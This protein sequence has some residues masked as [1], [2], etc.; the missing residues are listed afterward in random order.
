MADTRFS[1]FVLI[2][3]SAVPLALL[4]WD[5][6]HHQLGAD[7]VNYAIHTTGWLA[8]MYLMVSLCVTPLRKITRL[9]WLVAFRR[10]LG[11]YGFIYAACHLAIYFWWDRAHSFTSTW[12]EI[13]GKPFIT[14]GF[15][16]LVLLTPLALTST[17]AMI[18][19]LGP[20]RWGWLHTLAYPA[21]ALAALHY[22]LEGK[23]VTFDKKVFAAGIASLLAIRWI[24]R[25]VI[26]PKQPTGKPAVAT[27]AG[28]AKPK[29]W[30]GQL[31]IARIFRET[32]TVQTF[33][34]AATDGGPLPFDYLPGQY[35]NLAL[36]I[37]SKKVRR[38]YT[39]ASSPTRRDYCELTVKREDAG[40]A[41]R[42]LHDALQ[43]GHLLNVSAPA[44][45]FTF[46]GN[47]ANGIVLIAG[48]VGI[49]P[50]M[51]IA[52][53]LVDRSW[54]GPIN[55]FYS[56]RHPSEIIFA[57]EI[58]YLD[59][60]FKNFHPH[61][62]VT[63]ADEHEWTG[64]RGRITG[65]LLRKYVSHLND[66][67]TYICGPESMLEPM[68]E[69]VQSLGVPADR[70]KSEAFVSPAQTATSDGEAMSADPMSAADDQPINADGN[71]VTFTRSGK[72]TILQPGQTI[73]EA[74]E[75]CGVN[76]EYE[77][78]AGV[79]GTCKTHLAMGSVT[80]DAEDALG[81]ADKANGYILACQAHAAGDVAID[82]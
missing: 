43:E 2:F 44:G 22:W 10:T 15:S 69:V 29:F 47:E 55:L 28:V 27:A 20:K 40:L 63:R 5:A 46:T 78:R 42:Y 54:P 59:E 3:N 71:T 65:D 51:S 18:R 21:T 36:M 25:L 82:A 79:C 45:K 26:V 30:K 33:R 6:L 73:L 35:L 81:K 76:I 49:T 14:I 8:L 61:V 19:W 75:D 17:N 12:R 39:I 72:S 24:A 67:L 9:N 56:V 23:L 4:S 66:R 77:C 41:S 58:A 68:R 37:D 70:I 11:V 38:S 34:L 80:M 16:A 7:P 57:K 60:R 74:A 32:P 64:L 53:A 1:R 62:C 50:L 13:V 48:G 31:E 52:R